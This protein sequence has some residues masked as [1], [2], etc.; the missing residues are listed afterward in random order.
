VKAATDEYLASE[1]AISRWLDDC[2][3][4][5]RREATLLAALYSSWSG[6]AERVGERVGSAKQLAQELASRGFERRR[7]ESGYELIGLKIK[8][9]VTSAEGSKNPDD[10][11]G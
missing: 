1:D 6:W 11:F 10:I 7:T 2:C 8:V 5:D 9:D 4:R 3:S